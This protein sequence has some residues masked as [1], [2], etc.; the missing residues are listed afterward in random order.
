MEENNICQIPMRITYKII[1]GQP[2]KISAEY[3]DIPAD[4]IA[5][6]LLQKFGVD[7][8]FGGERAV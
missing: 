3:Q 8:I 7:A 1:D 2:V 6:F 4:L 5:Q